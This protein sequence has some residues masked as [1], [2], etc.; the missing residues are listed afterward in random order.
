MSSTLV[1]V[2]RRTGGLE[3]S[4]IESAMELKVD[5][6]TGGLEMAGMPVHGAE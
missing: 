2:D 5:R 4:V 1:L 6:R 3:K